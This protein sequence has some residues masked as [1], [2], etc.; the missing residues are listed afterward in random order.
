MKKIMKKQC[1]KFPSWGCKVFLSVALSSLAVVAHAQSA[2]VCF[3]STPYTIISAEDASGATAYRWLENGKLISGSAATFPVPD[4]KAVGNY[5]YIRQAKSEDCDEWQSSNEF[6]V[7]VFNCSFS[8]GTATGATA[9][10][11]DPRD[12]RA[13]KTVVMPDGK[14][15]FAQNL[16]Y[17]KDLTF[18]ASA[19]EANGKPFVYQGGSFAIGSY[20]CPGVDSK[21]CN[22]Y[23]AFYTMQTAYM[24]DGKY[25]DAS[26][27]SSV[28]NGAWMYP[29]WYPY[30]A[31]S[32]NAGAASNHAQGGGQGIC[33]KGWHIPTLLEWSELL[34]AI[35]EDYDYTSY[36][37]PWTEVQRPALLKLHALPDS[38]TTNGTMTEGS[39]NP[40]Y[41][42][43]T[44]DYGFRLLPAGH[45]QAAAPNAAYFTS[46]SH[47]AQ[48]LSSS[49]IG[50]EQPAIVDFWS[51]DWTRIGT[52]YGGAFSVRCCA[53]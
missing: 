27:T 37:L 49:T 38:V 11:T 50:E 33:P 44:D 40:A 31:I 35:D 53:D 42:P 30:S 17:T 46:R 4:N 8:A 14:T 26:K 20:W 24:I 5:T 34:N 7:T 36:A 23:G 22:V 47:F 6:V 18:N 51:S 41:E 13:Y 12:G 29:T 43:G 25:N 9:T 45:L 52:Y 48:M 3:G 21:S 39:W 15:W 16:N 32:V 1:K 10:F 19:I 28:W 2:D